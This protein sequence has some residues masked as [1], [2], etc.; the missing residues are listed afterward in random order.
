[1][2][3]FEII[4]KIF[5]SIIQSLPLLK[6]PYLI[7]SY[8]QYDCSGRQRC[9]NWGDDL[10]GEFLSSIIYGNIY[11]YGASPLAYRL[12]LTNFLVIGSTIDLRNTYNQSIWGAGLI[13]ESSV[14]QHKPQKIYAVRGPKTRKI[15]LSQGIDCPEIYGDPALLMPYYYKPRSKKIYKWG[16][17]SH[18]SNEAVLSDL[19]LDGVKVR[20][21]KDVLIISM[22]HYD[23]WK[24]VPEAI[25][26]CEKILSSS[27]HGLIVSE[28]YNIPSVWIEFGKPL[29]G[30]RFKFYDFYESVN[31]KNAKPII[32]SDAKI[33]VDCI[34]DILSKWK[35]GEINLSLLFNASP[36]KLIKPIY[37]D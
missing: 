21:R 7:N 8:V 14:L 23:N 28:A 34:N 36:F 3:F 4:Q 15:L 33:P 32:I 11:D 5:M 37:N 25:C 27:L 16:I 30:G 10:N 2:C 1:M 17:I 31:K 13:K 18:N 26:S 9:A 22:S 19:F 35:R 6:R 20:E 24:N 12:R 29:Y